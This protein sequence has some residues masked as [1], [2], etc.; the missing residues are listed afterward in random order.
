MTSARLEDLLVDARSGFASGERAEDG[1]AQV[2][3]NNITTDGSWDWSRVVRVPVKQS[4]T[5]KYLLRSGDV[6]FNNTNSQELVGKTAMFTGFPEPITFSNHFTRLRPGPRLDANYLAFWLHRQWQ[7]GFFY[8]AS[9]RWVGQ[10]AYGLSQLLALEL[11]VPDIS[12]QRHLAAKL[13]DQLLSIDGARRGIADQISRVQDLRTACVVAALDPDSQWPKTSLG[14]LCRVQ[15]GRT[16]SRDNP[17]Y[18]GGPHP[19]ATISDLTGGTLT[20]TREGVTDLAVE[21]A[22]LPPVAAGTLL[23]SFKLTI[24]KMAFAATDLYTNEAIAALT[25]RDA[26]FLD[27]KYLH[28]ALSVLDA[29][30]GATTAVMGRTLNS[31][32]LAALRVARPPIDVQIQTVRELEPRLELIDGMRK[33]SRARHEAIDEMSAAIL[34]SAIGALA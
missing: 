21:Q 6:L 11:H 23:Y 13:A 27:P 5:D 4:D 7:S 22:R 12:E 33:S 28:Y 1:V 18:W 30:A 29:D 15:I 19:W 3:M 17:D 34:R 10:A 26:R 14:D 25:P 32:T 31:Q 20:A 9:T 2:R 16:P 24:G 8:R